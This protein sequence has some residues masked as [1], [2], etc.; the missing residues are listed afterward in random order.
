M[1]YY[2]AL[3]R[4]DTLTYV[5]A[6]EDIMLCEISQSQKYKCCV[7]K[8]FRIVKVIETEYRPVE[9]RIWGGN[10]ECLLGIRFQFYKVIKKCRDVYVFRTEFSHCKKQ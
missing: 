8:L 1:E 6:Y 7:V 5:V 2:S 4:K 3:R 10:G 9:V